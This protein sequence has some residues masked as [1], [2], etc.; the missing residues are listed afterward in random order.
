MIS[1][2]KLSLL[3]ATGGAVL[4]F[5]GVVALFTHP[6]RQVCIIILIISSLIVAGNY[7]F[8][9]LFLKNGK[10]T[11]REDRVKKILVNAAIFFAIMFATM[12]YVVLP[13]YAN[14]FYGNL[15]SD[16]FILGFAGVL[17][18]E[19]TYSLSTRTRVSVNPGSEGS[20]SID[21]H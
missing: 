13:H 12:T 1:R 5:T 3:Y 19:R 16:F 21:S 4:S 9:F 18:A 6:P 14:M 7:C 8:V 11:V 20:D 2:E 10:K 17:L 15:V